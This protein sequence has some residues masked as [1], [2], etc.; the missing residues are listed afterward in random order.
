[1]NPATA[2]LQSCGGFEEINITALA[3]DHG[4]PMTTLWH[5]N[6]GRATV[7]ERAATQQYLTPSEEKAL[8]KFLLQMS[9]HGSPVRIKFLPSLAFS[10]ARQ[11]SSVHKALKPPGRN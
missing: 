7:R 4:V 9:N 11:R 6:R 10:I 1:M 2:A 3:K 8:S 5:R